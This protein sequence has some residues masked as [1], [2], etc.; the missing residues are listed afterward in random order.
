MKPGDVVVIDA[1]AECSMYAADITRTLPVSG[2]F[3]ARQR[4]IYDI[5][6]GAQ[7]AAIDA[8]QSGKSLLYGDSEASLTK[9]AKDYIRDPREGPS[10]PAAGSIFHSWDRSLHRAGRARRRRLQSS[11][12]PGN[13]LHHRAWNLHS[14]RKPGHPHRRRFPCRRRRQADQLS[15][16]LPSK[17]D[18]VEKIM[19]GK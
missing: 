14:G 11:A 16:A 8:F 6:L 7:Q 3:T 17:A 5:V 1:A 10:R 9:I 19:A 2:H 15:A 4:E 12:R 13:D 18:D